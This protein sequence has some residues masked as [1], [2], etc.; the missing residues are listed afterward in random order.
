MTNII[1]K[2]LTD[3]G[4]SRISTYEDT[5]LTSFDDAN[6]SSC[7]TQL[8]QIKQ[9]PYAN[10]LIP[11]YL[12]TTAILTILSFSLFDIEIPTFHWTLN[13]LATLLYL[14]IYIGGGIFLM[15]KLE[16]TMVVPA[17]YR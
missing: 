5:S 9:Y 13:I 2:L 14:A 15:E 17:N 12:F 4:Q 8:T 1:T 16:R 10:I 7:H 3:Y 11:L 6:R